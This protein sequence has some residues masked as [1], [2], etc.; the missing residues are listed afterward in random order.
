MR[1]LS[2]H[3]I[4]QANKFIHNMYVKFGQGMNEDE[5]IGNSWVAYMEARN[6]YS[7]ELTSTQYW[8][9]VEKKYG[10]KL[11]NTKINGIECIV[12]TQTYQ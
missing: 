3:E 7:Y 10:R 4:T 6:K 1:A 5:F 11:R 8:L 2:I 12:K 9:D